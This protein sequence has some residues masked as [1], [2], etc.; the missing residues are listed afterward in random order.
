[1]RIH[2]PLTVYQFHQPVIH[3]GQHLLV[4]LIAAGILSHIE[5][6][7]RGVQK[8]QITTGIIFAVG[9]TIT[10]MSDHQ[11]QMTCSCQL[12]IA[13]ST[14][15]K[16]TSQR[17]GTGEAMGM[18]RCQLQRHAASV[19]VSGQEN[20]AM[21][22]RM[23]AGGNLDRSQHAVLDLGT[24]SSTWPA[25]LAG[26][27]RQSARRD[28]YIVA[29]ADARHDI[30]QVLLLTTA[31][32]QPDDQ[33]VAVAWLVVDRGEQAVREVSTPPSCRPALL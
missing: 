19:L 30:Q 11:R 2:W 16:A 28:G 33:R 31:M 8:F 9:P 29:Q 17:D 25:R 4:Q 15:G 21:C 18:Q 12:S 7:I 10:S 27:K 6:H 32:M 24:T 5:C 14:A 26:F 20:P 13:S 3:I 1:M 23:V 22:E